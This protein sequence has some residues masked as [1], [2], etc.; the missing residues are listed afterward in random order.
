MIGTVID[1]D[2]RHTLGGCSQFTQGRSM[3]SRN[4][5]PYF[6][7]CGGRSDIMLKNVYDLLFVFQENQLFKCKDLDDNV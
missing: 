7:S 1:Q 2:I 4:F 3:S 6:S 5:V